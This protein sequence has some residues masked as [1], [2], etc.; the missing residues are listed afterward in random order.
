MNIT[1]MI[2]QI[3]IAAAALGLLCSAFALLLYIAFKK[4]AVKSDPKLELVLLQLPGS[5]CGA[6]G[7][8][9][10]QGLAENIVADKAEV[11]GCLA[12]GKATAE[13][14]AQVMGI[15]L[16][17]LA[18]EVAFVACRAGRNSAPTKFIYDGV[19]NCQAAYI[20]FGGDKSCKYGCLGFG[21]CMDA[22]PFGAISIT[23]DGLAIIDS[24][25]CRS[26][27]KC[28]IACPRG[29]I[30]MVPKNQ[31]VLVACKNLD[32]ARL[33]RE[34]CS[35]ACTA[36][37][38]CEKNCPEKAVIVTDNLAVIDYSKC[39]RCGICVEKCP[40]STILLV[41]AEKTVAVK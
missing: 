8:T 39:T 1:D 25:K 29:L 22:C 10:C 17:P 18:E 3:I 24:I 7:F 38:L 40:Q 41:G 13:K 12:G 23:R 20:L 16:S 15:S 35:I 19:N 32:K 6:C 5:N 2:I 14:L 4:L 31:T 34:V 33:A 36:C 37:K 11:T 21:S 26:C 27:K 30:K 28:I 9:G